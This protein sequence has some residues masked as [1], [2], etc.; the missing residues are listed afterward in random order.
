VVTTLDAGLLPSLLAGMGSAVVELPEAILVNG[1]APGALT[2][3]VKLALAPLARLAM[4]GQDTVPPLA[5]P[6]PVALRKI[7]PAGKV[8]DTITLLAL[9]GP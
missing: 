6:P 5:T 1:P 8:S 7:A 4:V 2:V 9:E 3:R